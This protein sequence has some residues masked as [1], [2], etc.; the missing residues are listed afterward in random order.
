MNIHPAA[1]IPPELPPDDY[2]ALKADIAANGLIHPIR[3]LDGM[4]L[5]GRHRYRACV[6][7]GF[8]PAFETYDGLL[9]PLAYVIANTRHRHMTAGQ[10]A[11]MALEIER[12][13][14]DEAKKRRGARTDIVELI[15]PSEMGK[16]RDKA[17]ESVGVN[18]RYVSDA[19]HL[20]VHAPD[21]LERVRSGS[22]NIIQA[23][24][25][26]KERNKDERRAENQVIVNGTSDPAHIGAHFATILLDPPW[27][28][29]D[30]GDGDPLGK[31]RPA[32]HQMSIEAIAALPVAELA[33]VDCHLYLWITNR[34]LPKG[35]ALLEA[36]GFRYITCL[37]WCKPHY[38]TGQYFRGQTEQV[39]FGVKGS[40]PLKRKDVGTWFNAARG[41][42]GHSSKPEIFYD[43]IE[44]CSPGPY[45]E[46]F[47]RSPRAGW[48]S[49]GAEANAA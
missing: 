9:S 16:A 32:Y 19:K 21:L 22:I 28:F 35:F 10:K 26:L 8:L 27:H 5:D 47:A 34:S 14:A 2:A 13:E 6:E 48:K 36:W 41:P 49:W 37:T 43:L 24:R 7:L 4:I 12:Y 30:E 44:S 3:T 23:K 17:A 40:Q 31:S 42:A 25:E 33:D 29:G 38:G 20:Q 11:C 39:L 18:P 46:M 45:L 15:P 1:L